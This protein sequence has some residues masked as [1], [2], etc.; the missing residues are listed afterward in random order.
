M[1]GRD[2]AVAVEGLVKHKVQ[3]LIIRFELGYFEVWGP[4][5]GLLKALESVGESGMVDKVVVDFGSDDLESAPKQVR[6]AVKTVKSRY[7]WD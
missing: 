2:W 4:H 1:C 5:R 6:L 7:G 3:K